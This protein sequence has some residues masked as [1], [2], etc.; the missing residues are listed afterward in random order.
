MAILLGATTRLRVISSV[1]VLPMRNP[2]IVAKAAQTMAVMSGDRV[3][4]GVGS[5]WLAEEFAAL[6]VPFAGRGARTDEAIGIVRQ[7]G[8]EGVVEWRGAHYDIPKVSVLPA[9][10]VPIYVGGESEAA[11]RRA[12]LL[13]DG[14]LST[15]RTRATL[16][17]RL[18]RIRT[19]RGD[20]GL[21]GAPF[22]F[23]GVPA[24]ARTPEDYA[25]LEA[26]GVGAAAVM[27]WQASYEKTDPPLARKLEALDAFAERFIRPLS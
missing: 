16:L 9:R 25:A 12:A 4:L 17:K 23:I 1:L 11:L 5:G 19:L 2:L 10:P 24:D 3:V 27:A 8:R 14:Y 6:G 15:L 22:E 26:D 13:G 20:A 18:A 21:A 7:L